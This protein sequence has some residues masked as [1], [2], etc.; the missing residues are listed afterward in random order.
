VTKVLPFKAFYNANF[1]HMPPRAFEETYKKFPNYRPGKVNSAEDALRAK[2]A[3]CLLAACMRGQLHRTVVDLIMER[4]QAGDKSRQQAMQ[5][6]LSASSDGRLQNAVQDAK[7]GKKTKANWAQKPSVCTWCAP[8][9]VDPGTFKKYEAK[10]QHKPSV[11]TWCAP[12]FVNAASRSSNEGP[13]SAQCVA[14]AELIAKYMQAP[15]PLLRVRALVCAANAA[16]KADP[17]LAAGLA[18][19]AVEV[20]M[21][22][23]AASGTRAKSAMNP[24]VAT[25]LAMMAISAVEARHAAA[26]GLIVAA[27]EAALKVA[28][29]DPVCQYYLKPS[30]GSWLRPREGKSD[31]KAPPPVAILPFGGYYKQN[32]KG[33]IES[34]ACDLFNSRRPTG[35][36]QR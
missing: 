20:A 29:D 30:V 15:S 13:A 14:P 7:S 19:A 33:T 5:V 23:A 12:R 22:N 6:L 28:E 18:Q 24:D 17:S 27:A 25:G 16:A 21:R 32:F 2:A 9:F 11:G 10:F 4:E 8:R 3:Q 31:A 35:G 26:P 1:K 36:Q 34:L